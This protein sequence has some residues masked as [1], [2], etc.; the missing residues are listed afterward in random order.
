MSSTHSPRI[1]YCRGRTPSMTKPSF[2]YSAIARAFVENTSR[3]AFRSCRS[4]IHS[5]HRSMRARPRP[6]S[7]YPSR[8]AIP[9][10]P[11]CVSFGGRPAWTSAWPTSLPSTRE[12]KRTEVVP[13]KWRSHS[14][15]CS[16][17]SPTP[18][19]RMKS[20]SAPIALMFS[21]RAAASSSVA[22]RIV[23]ARPSRRGR[24]SALNAS[25]PG[26]VVIGGATSLLW[27]ALCVRPSGPPLSPHHDDEEEAHDGGDEEGSRRRE[28]EDGRAAAPRRLQRER[29]HDLRRQGVARLV[30]EG[31]VE[32]H[33]ILNAF[34]ER[35]VRDKRER[36][37]VQRPVE[38]PVA[39]SPGADPVRDRERRLRGR[40]VHGLR[41]SH[42]DLPEGGG[43]HALRRPDRH[44]G[45]G[46]V[47]RA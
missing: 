33:A 26:G 46:R 13:S 31:P 40:R 20:T 44:R 35:G 25:F 41:E 29:P 28:D 42:A 27:L 1:R 32:G 9:R 8:I 5:R 12:T 14:F 34:G 3:D 2:L 6:M 21:W 4:R 30:L 45:P 36:G 22:G 10:V 43:D 24:V 18:S 15:S 37:P 16:T 11:T 23:A 38:R 19:V 7:R 39:G 47:Q 17:S